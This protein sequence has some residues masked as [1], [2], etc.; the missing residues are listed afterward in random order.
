MHVQSPDEDSKQQPYEAKPPQEIPA[1]TQTTATHAETIRH[2]NFPLT[3]NSQ[4]RTA[5][6]NF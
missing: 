4:C 1:L 5:V 6:M 3:L 2:C